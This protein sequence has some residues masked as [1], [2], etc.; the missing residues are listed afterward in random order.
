MTITSRFYIGQWVSDDCRGESLSGYPPPPDSQVRVHGTNARLT[1]RGRVPVVGR[2]VG[3]LE[4]TMWVNTHARSLRPI[5]ACG[6]GARTCNVY[7]AHSRYGRPV[8][9]RSRVQTKK[10][11][12][13]GWSE[14]RHLR[15]VG[16]GP[17]ERACVFFKIISM[18]IGHEYVEAVSGR[19]C[20]RAGRANRFSTRGRLD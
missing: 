18:K 13:T 2:S 9:T 14:I 7:T 20:D 3:R 8:R 16:M 4:R 10:K 1:C 12:R 15:Y 19:R 17:D 11:L 6:L 5:G